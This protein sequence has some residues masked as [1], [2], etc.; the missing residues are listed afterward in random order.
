MRIP[1][2]WDS[3]DYLASGSP[4]QQAA[5]AALEGAGVMQALAP[6]RPVLAGT[7]PLGIDVEGSDLDILCQVGENGPFLARLQAAFGH[8]P[9]FQVRQKIVG[10][11]PTVIARFE[12]G[13]FLVEVFGQNRP[14]AEQNG[15]RHML[16]EA[17]LL[18]L[19]GPE[20]SLA[21][22]D[23]KAGGLKTEPAFARYF[24]LPGDPYQALLDLYGAGEA[25]LR[26]IVQARP[27]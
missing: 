10:G 25:E 2:R 22:R 14:V 21:I 5:H 17:R 4:R 18:Q 15:Y 9:D 6:W 27:R 11:L 13:G 23:L 20:A 7:I 26:Q 24:G 16:V 8:R 1:K 12:A 3:T 19:A